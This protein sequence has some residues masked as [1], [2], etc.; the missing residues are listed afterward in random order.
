MSNVK[1]ALIKTTNKNFFKHWLL[2][3]K[4]LH[5]LPTAE[6]NILAL[7]LYYYF[8]YKKE[9]KSE[10]LIWKFV[11]DYTTKNKIK[12]ELN[13]KVDQSLQNVLYSLRKKKIINNNII[14]KSFIPNIKDNEHSLI[15][16]FE[17]I[18]D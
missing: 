15:F 12:K 13:I 17:I 16:K 9:I 18:D 5:K 1:E 14:S 3:T 6:I 2:L 7:L 4:P 8:E 11:F 10:E